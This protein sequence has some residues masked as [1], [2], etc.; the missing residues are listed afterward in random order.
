MTSLS[1]IQQATTLGTAQERDPAQG[2]SPAG[3]L[4]HLITGYWISQAIGAAAQLGIADY[5]G[6][7]GR[8]VDELAHVTACH[9]PSLYRLL[10]ALA[11]VGV[12]KESAP[13][14]FA[15]TPMGALLKTGMLGN[16]R[17]FARLQG[18]AWHWRSWGAIEQSVRTG[19]PA[20]LRESPEPQSCFDY[21]ASHPESE[22][23][24]SAAMSGYSAQV[25]DAVADAYDFTAARVV[26]DIG[27]GHGELLAL[28]LA[29]QAHLRGILFDRES[30]LQ[31]A[32][33][34]LARNAVSERCAII[35]GNFFDTVPAGADH[36]ILSAIL[37]DWDDERAA[38]LLRRVASRMSSD[39][40]VLIV[41]NVIPPGN[42]AHPGKLIDLE[43]LLITG[44]R[45]RTEAEFAALARSAGL[46]VEGIVPTAMPVSIIVARHA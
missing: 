26:A 17:A 12:F 2:F 25:S 4:L 29:R 9:A 40:R 14:E 37:H 41:E 18:D 6:R 13:R 5:L 28:I 44:G 23:L 7:Q 36:Y 35:A 21:L 11:S 10:R 31:G 43:M 16:L 15:L 45:E 32:P 33:E 27:G 24:F 1:D 42:E 34:M 20:L 3:Q 19:Q 39:A 8:P 22:A 38:V 30:V 46:K